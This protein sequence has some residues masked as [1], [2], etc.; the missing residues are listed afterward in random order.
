M[1][2]LRLVSP[3]VTATPLTRPIASGRIATKYEVTEVAYNPRTTTATI[4]FELIDAVN[5]VVKTEVV[6]G[7]TATTLGVAQATFDDLKTKAAARLLALTK[8]N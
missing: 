6:T 4:T 5:K 7:E 2:E 8:I 1:A 3:S